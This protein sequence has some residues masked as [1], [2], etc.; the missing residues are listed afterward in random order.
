M[1]ADGDYPL[2]PGWAATMRM[3]GPDALDD[4]NE[5]H[6][7]AGMLAVSNE[8]AALRSVASQNHHAG[9]EIKVRPNCCLPYLVNRRE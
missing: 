9:R 2:D 1:G 8:P 6:P 3:G 4:I 7:L 5:A